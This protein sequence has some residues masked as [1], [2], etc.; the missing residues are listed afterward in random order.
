MARKRFTPCIY[1]IMY[2]CNDGCLNTSCKY[3]ESYDE[4]EEEEEELEE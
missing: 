4:D 3:Y 1:D 2:P